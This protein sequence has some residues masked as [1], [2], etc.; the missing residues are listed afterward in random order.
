M[1]H[2]RKGIIVN[3]RPD[4]MRD[5][6][7]KI[8]SYIVCDRRSLNDTLLLI[9]EQLPNILTNNYIEEFDKLFDISFQCKPVMLLINIVHDRKIPADTKHQHL[10]LDD[11]MMYVFRNMSLLRQIHFCNTTSKQIHLLSVHWVNI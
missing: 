7:S 3:R 10:L 6:Y 9:P 5:L 8:I 4:P 2:L 11:I 1:N